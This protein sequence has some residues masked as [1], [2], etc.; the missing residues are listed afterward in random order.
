MNR[1]YGIDEGRPFWK[2][3]PLMILVTA[4]VVILA[5]IVLLGLVLTGPAATAVGDALGLGYDRG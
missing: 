1:I 5:A 4:V 3:R 2:F